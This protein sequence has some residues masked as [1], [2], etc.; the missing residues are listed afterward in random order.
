MI[1]EDRMK[2]NPYVI[3]ALSQIITN[4]TNAGL[5]SLTDQCSRIL[6]LVNSERA[7]VGIQPLTIN[8]A[9]NKLAAI[10]SQDIVEKAYFDHHSP[11]FG[12]SFDMM[13]THGINYIFA[14]ENLAIDVYADN[15]HA[16]WMNSEAH[17][18]NILNPNFTAI[19]I[20]IYAK[21]N[22]SYAYTQLF[23]GR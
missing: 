6:I 17:K 2:Y 7:K 10:K 16:A 14:G 5:N 4:M 13:K 15:A 12:S 11:T 23:I 18:R 19:G 1:K 22:N 21:G 3:T 9:L 8:S 20:G